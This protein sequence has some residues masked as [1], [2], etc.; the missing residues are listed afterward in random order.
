MKI[1]SLERGALIIYLWEVQAKPRMV[2]AWDVLVIPARGDAQKAGKPSEKYAG[3]ARTARNANPVAPHCCAYICN[4]GFYVAC[5]V[6]R[7][8]TRAEEIY[9]IGQAPTIATVLQLR[10][11]PPFSAIRFLSLAIGQ[12]PALR[13]FYTYWRPLQFM[14]LRMCLFIVAEN[15]CSRFFH[16]DVIILSTN[17]FTNADAFFFKFRFNLWVFIIWKKSLA[18]L[19]KVYQ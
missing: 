16:F 1:I 6:T 7:L 15:G 10:L 5:C 17:S 11:S 8:C 14:S 2:S 13:G 18:P 3:N 12:S 4:V 19:L 9:V